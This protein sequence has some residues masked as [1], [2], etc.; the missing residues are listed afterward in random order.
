MSAQDSNV[1]KLKILL[2]TNIDRIEK[3][4]IRVAAEYDTLSAKVGRSAAEEQR[5]MDLQPI[6]R[7]RFYDDLEEII[8]ADEEIAEKVITFWPDKK[9]WP[10]NQHE[11]VEFLR[12]L[13]EKD[14]GW[15]F[16]KI[17]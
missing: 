10:G 7:P 2:A 14:A 8:N 12:V 5:Y 16:E 9:K 1:E 6:A 3:E 17:E 4:A 13:R 15:L 11:M